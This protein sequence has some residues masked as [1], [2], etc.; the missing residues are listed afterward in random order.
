[1]KIHWQV[2]ILSML[3]TCIVVQS[4]LLFAALST[5]RGL[6]TVDPYTDGLNHEQ[7]LQRERRREALGWGVEPSLSPARI[8]VSVALSRSEP[9]APESISAD[10]FHPASGRRLKS[11]LLQRQEDR[12]EHSFSPQ[13][14]E[15][16]IW[17]LALTLTRGEEVALYRNSFVI[18]R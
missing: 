16:G 5:D 7:V 14:L 10:L 12:F 8:A 4:G 15:K 1:M 2:V 6:V 11:V 18:S 9:G 13:E 17:F 3:L